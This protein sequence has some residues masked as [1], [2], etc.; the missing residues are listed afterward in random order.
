MCG[1][2]PASTFGT[3]SDGTSP[4]TMTAWPLANPNAL[5][6]RTASALN[7]GCTTGSY[8]PAKPPS[9]AKNYLTEVH[10]EVLAPLLPEKIQVHSR[11]RRDQ[12][13][14]AGLWI[15]A[16]KAAHIAD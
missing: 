8:S 15:Q 4:P 3:R 14:I 7:R 2:I 5:S 12:E 6:T 11:A 9:V 13:T 10:A 1:S 16:T